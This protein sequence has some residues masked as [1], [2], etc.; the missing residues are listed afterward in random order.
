MRRKKKRTVTK[1]KRRRRRRRRNYRKSINTW[2]ERHNEVEETP[3]Q[4]N[5]VVDVEPDRHDHGAVTHTWKIHNRR[6]LNHIS[7]HFTSPHLLRRRRDEDVWR[8]WME[9]GK[10]RTVGCFYS[11][12]STCLS[13]WADGCWD[14]SI[15]VWVRERK[16]REKGVSSVLRRGVGKRMMREKGRCR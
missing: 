6:T 3:G 1:R 8:E 12:F 9:N 7:P 2:S 10:R 4:H 11:P 15:P 16:K 13:V 5:D 14:K